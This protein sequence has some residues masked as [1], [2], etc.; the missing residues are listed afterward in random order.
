MTSNVASEKIAHHA[1]Q[2]RQEAE[3]IGRKKLADNLGEKTFCL[4]EDC[5]L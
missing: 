3:E 2:L 1:L 4:N 5:I